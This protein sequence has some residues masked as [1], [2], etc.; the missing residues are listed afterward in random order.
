[1]YDALEINLESIFNDEWMT[2]D[3]LWRFGLAAKETAANMI[4]SI[5][6]LND[7]VINSTIDNLGARPAVPGSE[8]KSQ[9]G[10]DAAVCRSRNRVRF[11]YAD[12]VSQKR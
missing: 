10:N 11:P 2:G 5:T 9:H 7:K 12:A 1:M 3:P 8:R 6:M 4:G